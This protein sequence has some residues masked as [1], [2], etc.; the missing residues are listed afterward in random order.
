M[1]IF[2]RTHVPIAYKSSSGSNVV[3]EPR[4]SFILAANKVDEQMEEVKFL[5]H[6]L[7]RVLTDLPEKGM[8]A[9]KLTGP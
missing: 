7:G 8:C 6:E 9:C 5:D 3:T 2:T 1:P 4:L